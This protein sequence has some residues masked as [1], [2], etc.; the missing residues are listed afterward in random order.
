MSNSRENSPSNLITKDPMHSSSI[1]PS[2]IDDLT[3][4]QQQ[5]IITERTYL[6]KKKEIAKQ[7]KGLYRIY[8]ELYNA[9]CEWKKIV[10]TCDFQ[11]K[12][13]FSI[14]KNSHMATSNLNDQVLT[15]VIELY[16]KLEI[17]QNKLTTLN[18]DLTQFDAKDEFI[19]PFDQMHQHMKKQND[20]HLKSLE[21]SKINSLGKC[22]PNLK[23]Q[24]VVGKALGAASVLTGIGLVMSPHPLGLALLAISLA[25][26]A[27]VAVGF[28]VKRLI[29]QL[30]KKKIA[31]I[32]SQ[33][34]KTKKKDINQAVYAK[35][36]DGEFLQ[37]QALINANGKNG[38]RQ[39]LNE[40]H[41]LKESI[42]NKFSI[43]TPLVSSGSNIKS[44]NNII[45]INTY[46]K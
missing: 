34:D 8:T 4:L 16:N 18:I 6:A 30:W 45:P 38:Y 20:A 21:Q 32:N 46:K 10:K 37:Q 11:L 39:L 17:I 27:I 44:Q 12:N 24:K 3:G 29:E 33:I 25:I 41:K 1:P 15:K 42:F 19:K 26:V 5:K 40:T 36:S 9:K 23:P 22:S 7:V 31:H 14:Y 35:M 43:F 2:F 28:F 13:E